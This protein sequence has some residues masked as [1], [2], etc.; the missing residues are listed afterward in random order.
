ME[1]GGEEDDDDECAPEPFVGTWGGSVAVGLPV[2]DD[3][4]RL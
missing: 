3:E 2:T 4:E 1:P